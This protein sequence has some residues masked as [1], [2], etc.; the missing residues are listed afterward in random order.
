MHALERYRGDGSAKMSVV[1]C[2]NVNILRADNNINR[3]VLFKAEVHAFEFAA[4]EFDQSV[5][6]HNTVEDITLAD[7]VGN[8]RVLRLVIYILG[9]ADLLDATL[10]H[11]N[12]GV[13]HGERLLLIVGHIYKSNAHRLLN[14][15]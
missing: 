3:L 12:N 14:A 8:E 2:D 4:E 7:K 5:L 11:D 10:I 9:R 1:R 15:L 6:K 13:G